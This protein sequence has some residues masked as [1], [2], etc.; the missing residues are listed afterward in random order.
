MSI[1]EPM[2]LATDYLIALVSFILFLKAKARYRESG[3]KALNYWS[4]AFLATAF[5]AFF[6]GS[7]HGMSE[8][9]SPS[10]IESL[11]SL[12]LWSL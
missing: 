10:I 2:T 8:I 5:S 3:H 7:Y 11:W 12:A 4:F 9:L 6:G 1:S